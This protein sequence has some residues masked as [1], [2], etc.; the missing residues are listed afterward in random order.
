[1]EFKELVKS[2]RS[3]RAFESSPVPEEHLHAVL[4]AGKWAPS[5][6]NLQPWEFIII[7]DPDV[8]AQVQKTAETAKQEVIDKDGPGWVTKY[9]MDYI[10]E[11]PALIVVILDPSKGG[12]GNFFG[13]KNGAMQAASACVQNMMLAATELGLE[14]V[15]FTFFR[16]EALKSVLG[17]PENL[18]IAAVI[19]IGKSKGSAKAP[20]RKEPVVH[21]QQYGKAR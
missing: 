13:Q 5:P 3:C 7:T 20:P 18:D 19:P 12:L 14:T 16:P 17:V 21:Y 10:T 9:E 4:A 15:W 1:M 6:L 8:K 2:R 11:A